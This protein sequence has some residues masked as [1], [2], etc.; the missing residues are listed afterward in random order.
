VSQTIKSSTTPLSPQLEK[1]R[2]RFHEG[3]RECDKTGCLWRCRESTNTRFRE[4]MTGSI[5]TLQ[6]GITTHHCPTTRERS[7]DCEPP[8]PFFH[9]T[10]NCVARA[11]PG[12]NQALTRRCNTARH[13]DISIAIPRTENE[14]RK[15]KVINRLSD[16]GLK[17][18]DGTNALR[19]SLRVVVR[20]AITETPSPR[21]VRKII[22]TR[23]PVIVANTLSKPVCRCVND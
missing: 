20:V 19:V 10:K 1:F 21:A 13:C 16:D 15:T 22:L 14:K 6:R 9:V 12:L 17:S 2:A 5:F 3:Q 23:T 4:G 8:T 18:P 11:L 7:P